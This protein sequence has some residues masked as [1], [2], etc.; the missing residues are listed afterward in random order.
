MV[1][2][3]PRK[4]NA[5]SNATRRTPS[6]QSSTRNGQRQTRHH[7]SGVSSAGTD[8]PTASPEVSETTGGEGAGESDR[9]AAAVV[10]ED[11]QVGDIIAYTNTLDRPM[12]IL[13][14][15]GDR[16]RIKRLK[17]EATFYVYRSLVVRCAEKVATELATI[18]TP[19]A[20]V[21][22]EAKNCNSIFS[23]LKSGG[24]VQIRPRTIEAVR[25]RLIDYPELATEFRV[26]DLPHWKLE[27]DGQYLSLFD[28]GNT[29]S[30]VAHHNGKTIAMY[31][32]MG[33]RKV[34]AF[35]KH[36]LEAT[37]NTQSNDSQIVET[38]TSSESQA[39][40]TP[41]EPESSHITHPSS[42]T[43]LAT[44]VNRLHAECEQ[45]L[46]IAQ[47]A[48]ASALEHAKQA[49]EL[50]LSAKKL[51]GHGGWEKW[52]EANLQLPSSTATLYQRVS[53]RWD[54]LQEAGISS[55]KAAADYLKKPRA[56]NK[57]TTV[58]EM[59]RPIVHEKDLPATLARAQA[60]FQRRKAAAESQNPISDTQNPNP[61]IQNPRSDADSGSSIPELQPARP[62]QRGDR[63]T[64][65]DGGVE[66]VVV[67][68]TDKVVVVNQ[69]EGSSVTSTRF[70]PAEVSQ[71]FNMA[72]PETIQHI[73]GL[74]EIH[75]AVRK[76]A[77]LNERQWD[78]RMCDEVA[79]KVLDFLAEY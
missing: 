32:G 79:A 3:Q 47:S 56:L 78:E 74:S 25:Q 70:K 8:Q 65:K 28:Y 7:D 59:Q 19:E 64:P 30:P 1:A 22:P 16:F 5:A 73:W 50:L 14:I 34:E 2:A 26:G 48:Q 57:S 43:Q 71:K 40:D 66:G 41:T 17:D 68:V 31:G 37:A 75:Y 62:L 44:D 51:V 76:F 53:D 10:S 6:R 42:L 67:A 4:T 60:D 15:I 24:W 39:N 46:T 18:S 77:A 54:E 21:K 52:R 27:A 11:Y 35:L 55:V 61:K 23:N 72:Q 33:T 38:R 45:A 12:E 9:L 58:A 69:E 49:G 20:E 63:L 36:W 29:I 13:E